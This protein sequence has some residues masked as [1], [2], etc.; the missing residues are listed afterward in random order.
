MEAESIQF[1][2]ECIVLDKNHADAPGRLTILFKWTISEIAESR[3]PSGAGDPGF[4][5][6]SPIGEG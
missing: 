3:K 4:W 1:F 2:S 6:A 5:G